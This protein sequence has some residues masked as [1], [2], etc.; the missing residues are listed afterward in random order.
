VC[1]AGGVVSGRSGDEA[2]RVAQ[3][4]ARGAWGGDAG[5]R[6]GPAWEIPRDRD[7]RLRVCGTASAGPHRVSR[8]DLQLL[9]NRSFGM[10]WVIGGLPLRLP[11]KGLLIYC[12][13]R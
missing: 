13:K 4:V 7:G 6:R 12:W 5:W 2:L 1:A 3:H 8:H 9:R 11:T 10:A